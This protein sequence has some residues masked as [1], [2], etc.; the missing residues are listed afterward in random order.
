MA[1]NNN[2]SSAS[3]KCRI[4][5]TSKLFLRAGGRYLRLAQ[6]LECVLQCLLFSMFVGVQ[7]CLMILTGFSGFGFVLVFGRVAIGRGANATCNV[8]QSVPSIVF[9]LTAGDCGDCNRRF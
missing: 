7:L 2:T 3:D 8:V 4:I 1:T 5:L 6:E 9:V